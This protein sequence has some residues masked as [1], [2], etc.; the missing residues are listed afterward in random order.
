MKHILPEFWLR[1]DILQEYAEGIDFDQLT[2]LRQERWGKLTRPHWQEILNAIGTLPTAEQLRDRRGLFP[3]D[4][5]LAAPRI[6]SDGYL[7]ADEQQQLELILRRLMPWRKGPYSFF[8]I[9]IDSEWRSDMKWD[10]VAPSLPSL[11]DKLV[12][13]IGCSNG[14]YM[15]R[16]CEHRPRAIVGIDPSERFLLAFELFQRFAQVPNL[17]YE[18]LG[19]EELAIFPELFDVVF[20]FGILYHHR[21]P[22]ELLAGVHR[23]MK[24]GAVL[25]VESQS[26]PGSEPI[27]FCPP[28]RYAKA[29]NIYFIP[30]PACIESWLRKAGF[31]SIETIS[32]VALRAEEQR[33]TE[34]MTFESLTDF[35]DPQDPEKT[36]E[37]FPAPRRA[38]VRAVK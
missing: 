1:Q 11:S 20:C 22:L 35:L 33:R 17:Q 28:D 19:I 5:S 7:T 8:G 24:P 9:E 37:G 10:R 16:S 21:N 4:L 30:T 27:A 26:I 29:R 18:L 6:G 2:Q 3:I 15:F 31:S 36:V 25:L 13:D 32:D 23:V 14:Y 34:W 12:L 38:I